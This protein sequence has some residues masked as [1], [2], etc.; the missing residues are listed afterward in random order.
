MKKKTVH[1]M[2]GGAPACNRPLTK[3][4]DALAETR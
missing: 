1:F 2:V 3:V 4:G